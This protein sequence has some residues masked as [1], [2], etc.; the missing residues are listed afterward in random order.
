MPGSLP[1]ELLQVIFLFSIEATFATEGNSVVIRRLLTLTSICSQW[2]AA[3]IGFPALWFPI[4]TSKGDKWQLADLFLDRSSS[5]P[6][7]VFMV[8][9]NA[10]VPIP[11]RL[12]TQTHR[13]RELNLELFIQSDAKAFF[14]RVGDTFPNLLSLRISTIMRRDDWQITPLHIK[15]PNL[16]HLALYG[17]M[18][19]P[20]QDERGIKRLQHLLL[21]SNVPFL[22]PS[23][24]FSILGENPGLRTIDLSM[25]LAYSPE[26]NPIPVP[27]LPHLSS[28]IIGTRMH[29]RDIT[30]Y[31]EI[32]SPSITPH[33]TL[34]MCAN[35]FVD[36][37]GPL[38]NLFIPSSGCS[39]H[40]GKNTIIEC[41]SYGRRL[42]LRVGTDLFGYQG[43]PYIPAFLLSRITHLSFEA[44]TGSGGGARLMASCP[45]ITC[46]SIS[47]FSHNLLQGFAAAFRGGLEKGET[48]VMPILQEMTVRESPAPGS[49]LDDR[50]ME[51]FIR[52]FRQRNERGNEMLKKLCFELNREAYHGMNEAV[53][54]QR[55]REVVPNVCFSRV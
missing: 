27:L 9:L 30:R 11:P 2:R 50:D 7:R 25:P 31:L 16:T 17:P 43:K 14:Q 48:E 10:S 1:L 32:M 34:T 15:C 39:I 40:I 23:A 19:I 37:F 54:L 12:S 24:F 45:N 41:A 44:E 53:V 46:L 4:C 21:H 6:I 35:C 20:F 5:A 55:F 38:H 47:C 3:A 22:T 51:I 36:P 26:V 8:Q 13:L 52:L 33:T 42:E 28:V 49:S 29:S 18:T